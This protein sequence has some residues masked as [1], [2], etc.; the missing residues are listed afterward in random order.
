[1]SPRT[2]AGLRAALRL[3]GIALALAA[4][5]TAAA[6]AARGAVDR[7]EEPRCGANVPAGRVVVDRLEAEVALLVAADGASLCVRRF[8]I[9]AAARHEGAVL[10]DGAP[11]PAA[12]AATRASI[13]HTRARLQGGGEGGSPW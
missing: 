3:F 11:D 2:R 4:P 13:D 6:G 1:M 10:T 9:A 7:A 8:A 5:G 12:E